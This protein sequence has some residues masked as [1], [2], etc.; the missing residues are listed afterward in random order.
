MILP[1]SI[2]YVITPLSFAN[3][4]LPDPAVTFSTH[5]PHFNDLPENSEANHSPSSMETEDRARTIQ[6][7]IDDRYPNTRLIWQSFQVKNAPRP[8][9]TQCNPAVFAQLTPGQTARSWSGP[10]RKEEAPSAALD[11]VVQR[12]IDLR[13]PETRSIWIHSREEPAYLQS[14]GQRSRP[15]TTR[16]PAPPP[17]GGSDPRRH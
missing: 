11:K 13:Y 17:L 4:F 2:G 8:L 15:S 5:P 10:Q 6:R 16:N 12:V 7:V 14:T 9:T 1:V 3:L